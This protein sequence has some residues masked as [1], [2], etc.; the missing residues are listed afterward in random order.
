[1]ERQHRL[2]KVDASMAPWQGFVLVQS[3]RVIIHH[4]FPWVSTTQRDLERPW[5]EN[6]RISPSRIL[7]AS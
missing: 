3:K 2:R 4:I 7:A 5:L 1:M 6:R